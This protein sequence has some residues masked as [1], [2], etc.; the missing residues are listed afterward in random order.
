M[1]L[2]HP[3]LQSFSRSICGWLCCFADDG[4]HVIIWIHWSC[5]QQMK[6]KFRGKNIPAS[7]ISYCENHLRFNVQLPSKLKP[8]KSRLIP[9]KI[10]KYRLH[11][12][13]FKETYTYYV[14]RLISKFVTTLQNDK[15]FSNTQTNR[16][17][18]SNIFYFITTY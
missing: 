1:R 8:N 15:I 17:Q 9:N 5:K 16:S 3:Q 18:L 2:A 13:G 10:L 14:N 12:A 11:I 6:L 4:F 7:Y